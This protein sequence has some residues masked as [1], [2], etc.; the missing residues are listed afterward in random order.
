[1]CGFKATVHHVQTNLPTAKTTTLS[2]EKQKDRHCQVGL[3][4]EF[5]EPFVDPRRSPKKDRTNKEIEWD[6]GGDKG[7][8]LEKHRP[9]SQ[10]VLGTT[11][12][13]SRR[14]AA[15]LSRLF[16]AGDKTLQSH[17][18]NTTKIIGI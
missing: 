13:V 4:F 1:M 3:L 14:S 16:L 2:N 15:A 9:L 18:S 12:D 10:L 5:L 11:M 7:Y 17:R 8:D 6:S